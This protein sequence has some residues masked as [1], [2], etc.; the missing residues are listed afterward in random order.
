MESISNHEIAKVAKEALLDEFKDYIVY[1]TLSK[2]ERNEKRKKI[3][4]KLAAQE[5][6]HYKFWSKF[7]QTKLPVFRIKLYITFMLILRLIFG[8]TFVVKLLER[9]EKEIIKKYMSI[10]DFL[11]DEDKKKLQE[12][13]KDEEEHENTLINQID[14]TIVKYM[15]ALV[16][17]LAD[18]IIEITGAHAG[19]LGTTNNTIIAGTIGL[20]VGIGASISM[21]SASYLQAKQETG[22][23]PKISA[24]ITG[25]GYIITVLLISIPYFL[26]KNPHV[27]FIFSIIICIFL[28]F[29]FT[30]QSS[31]YSDKD[32]KS[33][34]IQ[35]VILLFSTA[36]LTYILGE[37]LGSIFGIKEIFNP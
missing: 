32:F 3:L 26:I 27:A 2:F 1:N 24:I 21:A 16:L 31:V 8:I 17:G 13:I 20:I 33:E 19:T 30:F 23:S 10:L 25:F 15:G 4:E 7:V 36:L 12:I 29:I 6:E 22:K 9:E 35:T 14:E 34:L 18:A 5:Y 11:S 37:W 28:I